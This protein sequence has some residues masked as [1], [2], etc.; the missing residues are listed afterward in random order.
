M[1]LHNAC[2]VPLTSSLQYTSCNEKL[3][4]ALSLKPSNHSAQA[5]SLFIQTLATWSEEPDRLF[6][7]FLPTPVT[8][9][10]LYARTT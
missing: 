2:L 4:L 7:A 1:T 5:L 3:S 9:C 6:S 8:A 10:M